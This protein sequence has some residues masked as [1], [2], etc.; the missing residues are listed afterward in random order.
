[1]PGTRLSAAH[2]R[3]RYR[4]SLPVLAGFA[5]TRC[6]EPNPRQGDHYDNTVLKRCMSFSIVDSVTPAVRVALE[7]AGAFLASLLLYH[8][9]F[10][11]PYIRK[12]RR[13]IRTAAGPLALVGSGTKAE[14]R[15]TELERVVHREVP[16]IGFV[17][18]NAFD[19]VGAQLSY[20]VALLNGEGE[21][22]VLSSIFSREET[23]TFGKRVRGFVADQDASKEER[24]AIA[25]ARNGTGAG[26]R[27]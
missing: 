3:V 14:Q 19:D 13:E 18:F 5:E 20:A 11:G 17:R 16:K 8:V 10:V 9:I 27:S 21:G 2:V 26:S 6:A 15:L 24:D 12:L 7:A 1:L 4:C 22:V 25:S 23:R